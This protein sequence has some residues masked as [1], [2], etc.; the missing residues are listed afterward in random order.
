LY[1]YIQGYGADNNDCDRRSKASACIGTRR[2]TANLDST[3]TESIDTTTYTPTKTITETIVGDT[4]TIVTSTQFETVTLP[5][6]TDIKYDVIDRFSRFKIEAVG[7]SVT[8]QF[9][10]T[11]RDTAYTFGNSANIFSGDDNKGTVAR[12]WL[13]DTGIFSGGLPML[14]D[15]PA[16]G[17]MGPASQSIGYKAGSVFVDC[18]VSSE[19][20]TGPKQ[21]CALGCQSRDSGAVFNW[22]C[23]G[24][25][26]SQDTGSC[27]LVQLYA[28]TS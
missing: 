4:T 10:T 16:P 8:G 14:A 20:T 15:Y 9:L 23:G 24:K 18:G 27:S 28:V 19:G 13:L 21:I 7:G 1:S 22:N 17:Q 26:Y 5:A 6:P 3:T 12:K 25:L 11:Q 2:A